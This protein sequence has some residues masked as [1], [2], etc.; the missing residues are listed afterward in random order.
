MFDVV[1]PVYKTE[2]KHLRE[3]IDSVLN[4]S[5]EKFQIYIS[6]GTPLEHEW[7]SQKVLKDYD[8]SRLHIIQQEGKGVSNA[9]NQ[10][11]QRGINPYIATLDSDDTWFELKLEYCSQLIENFSATKLIWG[12]SQIQAELISPKGECHSITSF[13]GV[14][15]GWDK[16][17]PQHRGF[18]VLWTPL[19]TSTQIYS[20]KIMEEVGWWD[21]T[22]FWGEDTDLN[23]KILESYPHD[24][25]QI[26]ASVGTYRVHQ[27]Q[28]TKG[29]A[30]HGLAEGFFIKDRPDTFENM[31]QHL[32]QNEP[33]IDAPYWEWLTSVMNEERNSGATERIQYSMLSGGRSYV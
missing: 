20:R 25:I 3:A 8:D 22:L 2:P 17:L 18:R 29:G 12:E 21:E 24:C 33:N 28:T 19:M 13:G 15:K 26:E 5:Y 31:I 23:V 16:T 1:I 10:A 9:R 6:D 11:G 4:Q 14:L 30:T 27:A 32:K 7:H